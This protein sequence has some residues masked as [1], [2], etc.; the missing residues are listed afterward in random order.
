MI[1]QFGRTHCDAM[2]QHKRPC[3]AVPWQSSF[4]FGK[5][6]LHLCYHHYRALNESIITTCQGWQIDR[7][8]VQW[9]NQS[10]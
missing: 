7:D 5:H 10:R 3:K 9:E 4:R 8:D 2:T 6:T 1:D